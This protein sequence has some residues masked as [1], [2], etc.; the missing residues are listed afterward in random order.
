MRPTIGGA[1]LFLLLLQGA[2]PVS[3]AGKEFCDGPQGCDSGFVTT[4]KAK[5][6]ELY[7]WFWESDANAR[8]KPVLLWMNGGPGA[9]SELGGFVEHVGPFSLVRNATS[10][11]VVPVPAA[12]PWSDFANVII[13]DQPV[14]AGYAYSP[15]PLSW[16]DVSTPQAMAEVY[17]FLQ[18]FFAEGSKHAQYRQNDFFVVGESYGGHYAPELAGIILRENAKRPEAERINLKGVGL[19]N[20]WVDP[21]SQFWGDIEFAFSEKLISTALRDAMLADYAECRSLLEKHYYDTGA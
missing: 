16:F 5:K 9:A 17:V 12:F 18:E 7:Y 20:G 1:L 14:G 15:D 11:R 3:A 4:N 2:I 19:G 21:V 6:H 13:L 10:Q 8:D